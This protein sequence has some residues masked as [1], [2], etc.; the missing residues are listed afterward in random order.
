MADFDYHAHPYIQSLNEWH[1]QICLAADA[2]KFLTH[3]ADDVP[4]S[5]Q[6]VLF[7]LSDRVFHLVETL[8]FPNE[9]QIRL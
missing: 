3:H 5:F 8:P 7:I 2:L 6:N 9:E 1:S 4:D